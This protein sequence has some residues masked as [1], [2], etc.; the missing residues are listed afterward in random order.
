MGQS[1]KTKSPANTP[2]SRDLTGHY[3]TPET[4]LW[5][6]V[7]KSAPALFHHGLDE[8]VG[9]VAMG[10][11]VK[12]ELDETGVWVEDWLDTSNQYWAW[13]EPLLE[14][15]RL[16]YS[17]GSASHLVKRAEDGRLLS[18]PVVEDTLTPVPAQHRLRAV[19]E[20]RAAYKAAGIEMPQGLE[21]ERP[22]SHGDGAGAL[23]VEALKARARAVLVEL[24]VA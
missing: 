3:F 20:I 5:L 9:L 14:A 10:H 7:Y 19:S 4:E 11:R 1:D 23:C 18:F 21:P 17:P 2:V 13:V 24:D 15:E 12:A 8:V 6:D 22:D 16:Y